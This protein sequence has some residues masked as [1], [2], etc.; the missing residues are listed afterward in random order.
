MKAATWNRARPLRAVSVWQPYA[1]AIARA[2]KP[3]ENRSWV[4]P[5]GALAPGADLVIHA[6][7]RA[8]TQAAQWDVFDRAGL[9][10]IRREE[11]EHGFA[12]LTDAHFGAVV[13][14][15]R[16]DGPVRA[17]EGLTPDEAP[18]WEGPAAWRLSHVRELRAPVRMRG[19]Q[20]LFVV[21][22]AVEAE[23]WKA[24]SGP[25]CDSRL[26]VGPGAWRLPARTE[27]TRP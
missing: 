26:W 5:F 12:S 14:V 18:W 17:L 2:W 6:S 13:A 27:E 8:L 23:L 15:A 10:G 21:P 22:P 25:S 16:F 11:L 1:L 20:G 4:P 24:L 7:A 19:Q 9:A 3:V